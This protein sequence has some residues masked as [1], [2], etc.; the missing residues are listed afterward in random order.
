MNMTS[1]VARPLLASIFISGGLDSLLHPEGKVKAAEHVTRPLARHLEAL[2]DDTTLLVRVNGGAQVAAGVL[3]SLG[4]LRRLSALVLIGSI[5]PTTYAGHRFW[6]ELDQEKR[7]Q[8]L[9]QVF[10]NLGLL[11]GLILA[12]TDNEGAP[13]LAWRL[14]RQAKQAGRTRPIG[15]HG[16]KGSKHALAATRS[17]ALQTISS[18][19][20][21]GGQ[22]L[23]GVEKIAAKE[24][25]K[26]AKVAS[27]YMR[28]GAE[29]AGE[30][31]SQA[32]EHLASV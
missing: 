16:S 30:L 21:S 1:R 5:I 23:R 26:G 32:Q 17:A 12:A 19:S 4:R 13:S 24:A 14:K 25:A 28:S 2:P 18:A 6:E 11:G 20:E 15:S 9:T 31:L 27:H 8:Q 10:K 22:A 7:S 29:L 3:L